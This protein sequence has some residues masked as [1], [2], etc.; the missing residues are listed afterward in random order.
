MQTNTQI[1][2]TRRIRK[3]LE[4]RTNMEDDRVAILEAQLSQAKL[5]AEEADKK[6][7]EVDILA[8]LKT[9]TNFTHT[10][11]LC[12][13]LIGYF[14]KRFKQSSRAAEPIRVTPQCPL[15][16]GRPDRPLIMY[17]IPPITTH[18]VQCPQGAGEP[19]S[20]R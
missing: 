2:R 1:Q 6:Y 13:G 4:N 7:E 19:F 20:D 5:I 9:Q 15:L 11:Q 3:A 14:Y 12:Q 16:P 10:Q 18:R 17:F 8:Y